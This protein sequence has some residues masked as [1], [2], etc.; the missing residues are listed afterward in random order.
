MKNGY[1]IGN[2]PICLQN[3]WSFQLG[4]GVTSISTVLRD[5]KDGPVVI[6]AENQ[7]LLLNCLYGAC[8]S[9]TEASLGSRDLWICWSVDAI[10]AIDAI[11][12]DHSSGHVLAMTWWEPWDLSCRFFFF[13]MGWIGWIP[14][15]AR[16]R[17]GLLFKGA[18][19]FLVAE[20]KK[21]QWLTRSNIQWGDPGKIFE[22]GAIWR[23]FLLFVYIGKRHWK[24]QQ[25]QVI[26][27]HHVTTSDL[28]PCD[29]VDGNSTPKKVTPVQFCRFSVGWTVFFAKRDVSLPSI[30]LLDGTRWPQVGYVRTLSDIFQLIT[31]W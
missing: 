8:S 12:R 2:I 3:W 27:C 10:D 24:T 16:D 1:F 28:F 26:S 19:H 29:C 31:L 9:S 22:S 11:D 30:L 6:A 17:I 23:S 7:G 4:P 20:M 15:I 5:P 14:G 13:P 18:S 25:V 21:A